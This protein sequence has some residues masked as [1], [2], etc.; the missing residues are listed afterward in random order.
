MVRTETPGKTNSCDYIPSVNL[1]GDNFILE[2]E[3]KLEVLNWLN[4]GEPKLFRSAPE[5]NYLV[6]LMN[7]SLTPEERLGRMVHT[8]NATAYEI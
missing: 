7:V 8:F 3:F 1:T 2:R 4:S 5:G 6:R